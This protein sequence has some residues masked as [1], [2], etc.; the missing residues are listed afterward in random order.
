MRKSNGRMKGRIFGRER[1]VFALGD[2]GKNGRGVRFYSNGPIGRFEEGSVSFDRETFSFGRDI[3]SG[4]D[5]RW[6]VARLDRE[7]LCLD[8]IVL[9]V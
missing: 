6:R 8:R 5:L 7:V 1:R 9:T 4:H 3:L 2:F